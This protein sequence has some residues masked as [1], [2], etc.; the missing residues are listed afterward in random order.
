MEK[1]DVKRIVY[2][3]LKEDYYKKLKALESDI[4]FFF[5]YME[6]NK[7]S[8][9]RFDLRISHEG[10]FKAFDAIWK[11]YGYYKDEIETAFSEYMLLKFIIHD[12]YDKKNLFSIDEILTFIMYFEKYEDTFVNDYVEDFIVCSH[13]CLSVMNKIN[14]IKAGKTDL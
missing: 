8:Y 1:K 3:L 2:N 5:M 11:K 9:F 14:E 7:K 10:S 13:G 4:N 12:I 6:R